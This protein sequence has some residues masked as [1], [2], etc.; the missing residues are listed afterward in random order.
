MG[1]EG[2]KYTFK[3]NATHSLLMQGIKTGEHQHTFGVVLYLLAGNEEELPFYK[4]EKIVREY[5]DRYSGNFINNIPPFDEV[6]PTIENMG[7]IWCH[8]IGGILK[9]QGFQMVGFEI[10]E[11][12][13]STFV[14]MDYQEY[15]RRKQKESLH[16]SLFIMRNMA[17]ISRSD[18]HSKYK[19]LENTPKTATGE[20]PSETISSAG[21]QLEQNKTPAVSSAV[22]KKMIDQEVKPHHFWFKFMLATGFVALLSVFLMLHIKNTNLYP[23]GNDIYGH[24]FKTDLLYHSIRKGDIFPLYTELWYNGIQPFRYWAPFPY[25]VMVLFQF[26]AH[27]DVMNAYL[28]FIAFS[29]FAGAMGWMIWGIRHRRVFFFMFLGIV[30]FFMPDNIRVFFSEGN[31]PRMMIAILIPYT[32][33]FI[34]EFIEYKKNYAVFF[35]VLLMCLATLTH[36]MMAAMIGISTF[37][38]VVC[39]AFANRRIS[40]AIYL[41][42]AMLTSF[43]ICGIWLVPGLQ[44][45][46]LGMD[47]SATS[48]VMKALSQNLLISINPVL[49]MRGQL[50]IFYFGFSVVV[51]SVV[52]MFLA[53]K[54]SQPG[55][56]TAMI[57]L[58]GTTTVAVPVLVKLPL[59]QLLWMMRFTTIAY[60][61]FILSLIEWKHIRR[62]FMIIICLVLIIDCIPSANIRGYYSQIAASIDEGILATKEMT[63]QRTTLLDVSTLGAFPSYRIC[64][65]EPKKQYS[66]GW[67]WQGAVTAPNIVMVNT[68]LEN[69]N[70]RYMFDR[71]HS[72]GD[73]T[74]MVRKDMVVRASKTRDQ[75]FRAAEITGYQFVK[76]D[77]YVYIFQRKADGYFGV[78]TTYTGIAIGDAAKSITLEFPTICEG[79]S[80]I[81]D[82]YTFDELVKYHVIYL[83]G[84]TYKSQSA[85]ENLVTRLSEAGV[86]IAIDMNRIPID[87]V[88]SR[89]EFLNVSSQ[90]IK[91]TYSFP[92]IIYRGKTYR[93]MPFK[94][95]Q[96]EWNTVFLYN[97][98]KPIG[99]VWFSDRKMVGM[100]TSENGNIYFLGLNILFHSM[101]NKDSSVISIMSDAL[102]TPPG[103]LPENKFVPIDVKFEKDK[104]TIDTPV[105]PL[106]TT[107]AYQDI[108]S[109]K[110][111]IM[112]INNLLHV[113]E[114]HTEIKMSYPY[115]KSGLIISCIGL[116]LFLVV[117]FF[118]YRTRK[119]KV[120]KQIEERITD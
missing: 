51:I 31:L 71:C 73:D 120:V 103:K 96:K 102:D 97:A 79:D 49:R 41:I 25:Y 43:A 30:W 13:V 92:A 46:L 108:F 118:I 26:M 74:V 100:G 78:Q 95:E 57:I 42:L 116:L 72:L 39:D 70:Y 33:Y 47:A 16:S 117:V 80:R 28:I 22:H 107:L 44:G 106:N 3:V 119:K 20:N 11:T 17:Q 45:G 89:M 81:L 55:F 53:A 101:S 48:E 7:E 87:N 84:F 69:G 90:P 12:P 104:I 52:G 91:F 8:D 29:F 115:F 23:S 64:G 99:Y 68:A 24:I 58:M 66:F 54:R 83:S 61:F 113:A 88:T 36:V 76:E 112:N 62:Y 6:S 34:W 2:Y 10:G 37:I 63:K 110:Q 98:P 9:E 86:R 105:V 93:P 67:A 18:I 1:F 111:K 94:E 114:K 40:R 109:S 50:D 77:N 32:V 65:S 60:A 27:G 75:L 59:N 14:V 21:E 15:A 35:V 19:P 38:F 82:E 5:L 56:Y 85:A 4:V